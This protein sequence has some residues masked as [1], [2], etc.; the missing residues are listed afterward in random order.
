[1]IKI[2]EKSNCVGCHA[3][4]SCCPVSCI[5]MEKDEEGFLYPKADENN[6][7]ACGICEEVCPGIHRNLR[8]NFRE[9]CFAGYSKDEEIRKTSSSGGVFS[10]L[11][12]NIIERKGVIFGAAFDSEFQVHHVKVDSLTDLK[13]LKGSKYVQSRIENTYKETEEILKRGQLVYFSGTPCQID[14]LKNYLQK[15]YDNLITQDFICHGVPAPM[16]WQKY[17]KYVMEVQHSEIKKVSFRDKTFG[18]RQYA[19]KIEFKNGNTQVDMFSDNLMMKA[20]LQDMC[21]RPSC[22]RCPSK[23]VKRNSDI[24]L[25]DFWNIS[26]FLDDADDNKG[27]DLI[28]CHSEKGLKLWKTINSLVEIYEVNVSA[29]IDNIQM[30]CSSHLPKKRNE[31]V[32]ALNYLTFDEAVEKYCTVPL[33]ERIST[34]LKFGL[35]KMYRRRKN[36]SI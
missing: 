18:W 27:M 28:V 7:I 36:V 13:S 5:S 21:L 26:D 29:A 23:G 11:A 22:Y 32:Q 9:I 33:F 12:K 4:Y 30:N 14:G 6:C 24:T 25:A 8:E 15:E 35:R 19:V 1:M 34:K 17:L 31:F 10:V 20:Y 2:L 3:C 16:V